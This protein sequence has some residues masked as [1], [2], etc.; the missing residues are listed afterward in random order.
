MRGH[1]IP[2]TQ[3]LIAALANGAMSRAAST[4]VIASSAVA[5]AAA[6]LSCGLTERSKKHRP[7]SCH[8]IQAA[9]RLSPAPL[10][11]PKAALADEDRAL[12][13]RATGRSRPRS[14]HRGDTDAQRKLFSMI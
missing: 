13:W 11:V 12:L 5:D 14:G 10:H 9:A 4:F 6:Q 8:S 2:A 1:S 3:T 7:Q